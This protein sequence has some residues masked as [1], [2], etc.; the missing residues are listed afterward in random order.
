LAYTKL[1]QSIITSTIWL[2]DDPTRIVWITMLALADKHGEVQGSVPGLA[3]IAGVKVEA[4][5]KALKLFMA[6]DK[7]S[8]TKDLEGRRIQEIDGGWMLIN[9]DKYRRMASRDDRNEK[10]AERVKRWRD[11]RKTE[12]QCYANETLQRDIADSDSEADTDKKETHS[13]SESGARKTTA[14]AKTG[15]GNGRGTRLP[16]DWKPDDELRSFATG[17]GLQADQIADTFGDYWRAVAG[18]RGRKLDWPATFRNWCRREAERT[19]RPVRPNG[20]GQP[21]GQAKPSSV[22]QIT[23]AVSR[24]RARRSAKPEW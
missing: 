15:D 5:A 21:A 22:G 2:E 9:H 11:N 18:A 1:F 4:C 13:S 3:R 24:F 17:L 7:D 20:S 8:R 12:T 19:T 23:D 14:T 16:D 10:S 6:P